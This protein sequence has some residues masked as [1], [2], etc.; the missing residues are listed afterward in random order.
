MSKKKVAGAVVLGVS[1]LATVAYNLLSDNDKQWLK[2]EVKG[3]VK[4]F[5][6]PF[7]T[8]FSLVKE[9]LFARKRD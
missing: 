2:E 1:A 6:E 5:F 9:E 4:N 7:T 8:R 3:R